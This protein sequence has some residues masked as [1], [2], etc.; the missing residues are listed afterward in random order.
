MLYDDASILYVD[1][2]ITLIIL[3]SSAQLTVRF[4]WIMMSTY[5]P[6]NSGGHLLYVHTFIEIANMVLYK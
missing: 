2:D 6:Q 1:L 4:E 5:S 3:P